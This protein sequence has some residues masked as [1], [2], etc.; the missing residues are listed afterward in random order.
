MVGSGKR[1][2]A[3]GLSKTRLLNWLQCPKRLWLDVNLE[4]K[5]P[6]DAGTELVF[7][8][9]HEVG[10]AARSRFASGEL[11]ESQHDLGAALTQTREALRGRARQPLFEA[12]FERDGL[13]VRADV[14]E[15]VRGGA[16]SLH[17]VKSTTSVKDHH[18]ADVAVQRWVLQ[19][20]GLKL[21][22]HG[23][24]HV[25]SSWTYPGDGDHSGLFARADLSAETAELHRQVEDWVDGAQ[26][27]L[28]GAEPGI[29]MGEQCSDPYPCPYQDHCARQAGEIEYPLM[30]LPGRAGKTLARRLAEQGFRDL[31]EVPGELV[32]DPSLAVVHRVT[33]SGRRFL[34]RSAAEA[35]ARLPWPRAYLDFETMNFAVPRW[36]G[37]RPYQQVPFQWSCHIETA[38]G[39]VEH[40]EFLDVSGAD[41][42]RACAEQLVAALRGVR[43]VLVYSAAFERGRM[44]ELADSFPDLAE[45][46]QDAIDGIFDLLPLVRQCY[47]HREMRGSYSLKAVLPTILK[48]DPYAALEAV[49]NGAGAQLAYIEALDPALP[50]ARR[51]VLE[52][53]LRAYCRIDSWAMIALARFLEGRPVPAAP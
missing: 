43:V 13:L 39:R 36:A 20:S 45:P 51:G 15:P 2:H 10:A 19:A 8:Q 34:D 22:S 27:T 25:E 29:A 37:T 28:A 46:I 35:I 48:E 17:E 14:L 49:R 38:L 24:M 41:P 21:A 32:T 47:Y 50:A 9:G 30:I 26:Q 1:R 12:A 40:V 52:E 4:D 16:W 18:H 33:F 6:L 44:Q 7:R 11:I 23:L 53:Q 5:P 3:P 42:R 31:R